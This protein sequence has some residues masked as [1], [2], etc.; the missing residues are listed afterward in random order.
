MLCFF[1][2]VGGWYYL[3]C[4]VDKQ[5]F[6]AF[7]PYFLLRMRQAANIWSVPEQYL[8]RLLNVLH[9]IGTEKPL[10]HLKSTMFVY[11]CLIDSVDQF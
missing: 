5:V 1:W 8:N 2:G 7:P 9:V 11:L 4:C 10:I 3:K 6:S